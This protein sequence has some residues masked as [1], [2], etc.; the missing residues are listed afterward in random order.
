MDPFVPV[1][2]KAEVLSA[3]LFRIRC[4]SKA[5]H[6]TVYDSVLSEVLANIST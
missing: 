4:L 6:Q 2:F 3:S 1:D 5:L